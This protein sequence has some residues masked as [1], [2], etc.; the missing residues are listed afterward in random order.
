FGSSRKSLS[1]SVMIWRPASA[2]RPGG[3]AA[4]LSPACSRS[5]MRGRKES[6]IRLAPSGLISLPNTM[7]SPNEKIEKPSDP[8][9]L[10][11]GAG[12]ARRAHQAVLRLVRLAPRARH[13]PDRL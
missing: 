10:H 5:G 1:R 7:G 9:A 6:W 8:E 2:R 13:L 4:N 11:L 12:F 3:R